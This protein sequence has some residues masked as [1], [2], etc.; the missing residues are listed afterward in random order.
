MTDA[1]TRLGQGIEARIAHLDAEY[2]HIAQT[3]KVSI[4]TLAKARTG[5]YVGPRSLAKISRALGWPPGTAEGVLK[6][7]HD[8]PAP[9]APL[10]VPR[11]TRPSIEEGEPDLRLR[12]APPL[13]PGESLEGWPLD[14]DRWHYHYRSTELEGPVD[15]R[16]A[17][18]VG[19]GLEDVVKKMRAMAVVARM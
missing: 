9:D 18:D 5:K 4:E 14:S 19:V 13:A 6:G 11:G 1:R 7:T 17:L 8:V 12:D 2:Q 10:H 16:L 15:I 3:A